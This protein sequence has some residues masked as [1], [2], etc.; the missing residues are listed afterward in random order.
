ML[1]ERNKFQEKNLYRGMVDATHET[2]A[3]AQ[4]LVT[5]FAVR[6]ARART[7]RS[8]SGTAQGSAQFYVDKNTGEHE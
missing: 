7:S 6:A 4:K 2:A 5:I 3:T 8:M 1:K